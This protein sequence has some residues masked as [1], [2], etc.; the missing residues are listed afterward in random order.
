MPLDTSISILV[1]DDSETMQRIVCKLLQ[2]IGCGNVVC[3]RNG[4]EALQKLHEK[5]FGLVISDWYMESMTGLKLTERIRTN[6]AIK[7]LP[8]IVISAVAKADNVI[9]AKEAGVDAYVV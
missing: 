8:V 5:A 6:P 2:S 3:A 4:M 1:V 9:A 7:D